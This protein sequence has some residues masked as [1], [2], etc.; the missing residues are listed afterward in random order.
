MQI[1]WRRGKRGK[2]LKTPHVKFLNNKAKKTHHTKKMSYK[3]IPI[4]FI[5]V[6]EQIFNATIV[7]LEKVFLNV[8]IAKRSF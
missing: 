6:R 2:S 5:Q 1:F 7:N 8:I 3:H 4:F